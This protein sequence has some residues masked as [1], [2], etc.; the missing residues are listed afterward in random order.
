MPEPLASMPTSVIGLG[1]GRITLG[2]NAS[3]C[4]E[5]KKTPLQGW[6]S[7]S[8]ST[9]ALA[10]ETSSF[11]GVVTPVNVDTLYQPL[12]NHPVKKFVNKLCLELMEGARIG[13]NGPRRPRF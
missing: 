10:T 2:S 7:P 13:Y 6:E 1:V 3:L 9:T 11:G 12:F 4:R 8:P 5:Q